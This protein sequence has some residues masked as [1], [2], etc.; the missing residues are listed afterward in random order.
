MWILERAPAGTHPDVVY[1]VFWRKFDSK[2]LLFEFLKREC[3]RNAYPELFRYRNK[4]DGFYSFSSIRF[5]WE[6]PARSRKE[7]VVAIKDGVKTMADLIAEIAN[8]LQRLRKTRADELPARLDA[9][10][11]RLHYEL[12]DL[13]EAVKKF[14][15][16]AKGYRQPKRRRRAKAT[17]K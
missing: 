16:L 2:K 3:P 6:K 12:L 11:C 5:K 4:D 8:I 9:P 7:V 17:K 1:W 15:M 10:A 13:L 14:K